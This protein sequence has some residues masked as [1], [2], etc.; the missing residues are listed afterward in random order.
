MIPPPDRTIGI[1]ISTLP[2]EKALQGDSERRGLWYA[3]REHFIQ[4]MVP[5]DQK[6]GPDNG[7]NG[8]L[9]FSWAIE[10]SR[11]KRFSLKVSQ[12]SCGDGCRLDTLYKGK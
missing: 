12:G 4:I 1:D 6:N 7:A 5:E 2:W 3:E 11:S 8:D 9:K 10:R